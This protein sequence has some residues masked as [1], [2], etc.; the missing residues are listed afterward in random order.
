MVV[1][2]EDLPFFVRQQADYQEFIDAALNGDPR[3]MYLCGLPGVGKTQWAWQLEEDLKLHGQKVSYVD[4]VD[5][6]TPTELVLRTYKFL[7]GLLCQD[8]L[9]DVGCELS[10]VENLLR[11]VR[12]RHLCGTMII[13]NLCHHLHREHKDDFYNKLVA[14][15]G[16]LSR[17]GCKGA[18]HLILI[19][20]RSPT[21]IQEKTGGSYLEGKCIVRALKPLDETAILD[22]CSIMHLPGDP[23]EILLLTGGFPC[24]LEMLLRR[25]RRGLTTWSEAASQE[26]RA[27]DKSY[28]QICTFFS[29]FCSDEDYQS[30]KIRQFGVK[31]GLDFFIWRE[32][33]GLELPAE[34]NDEFELYGLGGK[35]LPK[36]QR[37][38]GAYLF[39]CQL[40]G[41]LLM[42]LAKL[43]IDMRRLIDQKL[44][45]YYGNP[46]WF[47]DNL[48][49]SN[50]ENWDNR[51]RDI[52]GT[53]IKWRDGAVEDDPTASSNILDYT[54]PD[55]L[56][57]LMHGLR[58][59]WKPDI[60]KGW[61]GFEKCFDNDEDRFTSAM[62]AFCEIRN[63]AHHCRIAP[64]DI[65][66]KFRDGLDFLRLSL[67]ASLAD[68]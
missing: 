4:A 39:S 13:D 27:L 19:A 31:N 1:H 45:H 29:Q 24:R 56:L 62:K 42:E 16:V 20:R 9:I 25:V 17:P 61:A 66:E 53:L 60:A 18:L 59:H 23:R 28:A 6:R 30:D 38:L 41:P 35:H 64:R 22:V 44:T 15:I 43:E 12:S 34:I 49:I 21:M 52:K 46:N 37:L 2:K 10:D 63:H 11:E 5:I 48:Q 26:R 65:E 51:K 33:Y 8:G 7:C 54:Y 55:D 57:G 68:V 36:W 3:P 14:L 50:E 32:R 67:D 58:R 47:T 40:R